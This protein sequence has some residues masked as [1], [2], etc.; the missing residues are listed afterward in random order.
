[1][2]LSSIFQLKSRRKEG[3]IHLPMVWASELYIVCF[4]KLLDDV[5]IDGLKHAEDK[6]ESQ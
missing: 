6:H 5:Y 4:V 3:R 1:M 2:W